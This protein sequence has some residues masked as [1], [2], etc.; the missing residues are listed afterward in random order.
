MPCNNTKRKLST[1][2]AMTAM[3]KKQ[4]ADVLRKISKCVK[5][6][7]VK[8]RKPTKKRT[9]TTTLS[10]FKKCVRKKCSNRSRPTG[11]NSKEELWL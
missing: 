9:A 8:K 10:P 5:K 3:K 7:S 4:Q 1:A 6:T 11:G 2:A